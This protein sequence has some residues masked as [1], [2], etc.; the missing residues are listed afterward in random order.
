MRDLDS[1]DS[2]L[3]LITAVRCTIREQVIELSSRKVDEL[4]SGRRPP[5]SRRPQRFGDSRLDENV[6]AV[7]QAVTGSI[8][9]PRTSVYAG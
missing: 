6:L 5:A 4:S 1:I 3:R 2:E 8:Q 7:W 9:V